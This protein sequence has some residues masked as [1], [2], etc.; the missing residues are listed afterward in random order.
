MLLRVWPAPTR[1]PTNIPHPKWRAYPSIL[2]YCPSRRLGWSPGQ[3][4]KGLLKR[5]CMSKYLLKSGLNPLCGP[6]HC[7]GLDYILKWLYTVFPTQTPRLALV[8]LHCA[9]NKRR[10]HLHSSRNIEFSAQ[11]NISGLL[12]RKLLS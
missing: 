7:S 2:C 4:V 6:H 1:F 9:L 10:V 3:V 8:R 5:C 11:N 12:I